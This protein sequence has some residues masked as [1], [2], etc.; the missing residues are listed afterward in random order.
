VT[1]SNAYMC[2]ILVTYKPKEFEK[3]T[4]LSVNNIECMKVLVVFLLVF[5]VRVPKILKKLNV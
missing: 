4:T 2:V 1:K 5:E 3:Q